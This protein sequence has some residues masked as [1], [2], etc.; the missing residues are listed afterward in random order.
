M[1]AAVDTMFAVEPAWHGLG[2]IT[3][4]HLSLAE[5]IVTGGLEW[6]VGLQPLFVG[7]ENDSKHAVKGLLGIT[8]LDNMTLLG[9][10]TKR[11]QIVQND[12]A[13]ALVEALTHDSNAMFETA[14]SLS[15]GRRVW[16][17]CRLNRELY[18][19]GD[20]IQ[21]YFLVTNSHDGKGSLTVCVT[22]IR[23]VCQNTLN[24]ALKGA[25]R[26][27]SV[28][29]IGNVEE[30]MAASAEILG[31]TSKYIQ[32]FEEFATELLNK[33]ITEA[34]TET[35]ITDVLFPIKPDAALR[36]ETLMNAARDIVRNCLAK[37]DL[38]N[39][40]GTAWGV[41]NAVGDYND[42]Y[43]TVKGTGV[44]AAETRFT[45]SF[46]DTTLRDEALKYLLAV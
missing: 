21:P 8:R 27:I 10:A 29:H 7:G 33:K 37:P 36:G 35:L 16:F 28:R 43:R 12:E 32:S 5:A 34:Q 30:R 39:V 46:E 20:E 13:G 41:W 2:T 44:V 6:K 40:K 9:T 19:A 15:Y 18:V 38:E 42:H 14:G 22:P 3:G 26:K 4:R 23:V 25:K 1:P 31:L 11:Y 45:R 24:A 17:L